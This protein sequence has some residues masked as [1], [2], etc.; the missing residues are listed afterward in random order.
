MN[1][2][3]PIDKTPGVRCPKIVLPRLAWAAMGLAFAC[4]F[5]PAAANAA[6]RKSLAAL[7][8][9]DTVCKVWIIFTDKNQPAG[10][11]SVTVRARVRRLR[12]GAG[13]RQFADDPVSPFYVKQVEALGCR[14]VNIFKWANAASFVI[15]SS[16]L[17]S[18]ARL[19]CVR[20]LLLVRQN[21]PPRRPAPGKALKKSAAQPPDSAYG[22]AYPELSMLAV[23]AAHRWLGSNRSLQ[24][25][26]GIVVAVFDAGFRLTHRCYSYLNQ[27]NLVLADSDFIDHDNTVNDPDSVVNDPTNPYWHNDEH[28]SMTLSLIAGYDP[29]NFLGVAWDAR[30]ILA[31]TEDSPV[32]KHYE[33][34]NWAAAMVWA[35]SLGVDIVSSS[36]GYNNG[37]TPPDTDYTFRDMDG[38]TTIIS[39]AASQA[40][41]LGVIIVNA[42]GNDG[43]DAGTISAPADTKD[44]V[45]VGAVDASEEIAWFS[46]RGPTA[47]GRIKP[48]CSALGVGA[49]I[50][51][52]YGASDNGQYTIDNGTSFSAPQV[53]G[54]AA[55]IL[56]AHPGDSASA[57]RNRLYSSCILAPG[58]VAPDNSFGRGIPNALVALAGSGFAL[59]VIVRD[60]T[61]SAAVVGTV[62]FKNPGDASFLSQRTDSS[63]TAIVTVSSPMPELY[64]VAPGYVAS[65]RISPILSQGTL[66][67]DTLFLRPRS[68]S[69]FVIYPNVLNFGARHQ[70][71]T[72]EFNA[73]PGA[74]GQTFSA[75]IRS[76][77]GAL[78]WHC[79]KQVGVSAAECRMVAPSK[80]CRLAVHPGAVSRRTCW[81][82]ASVTT[83]CS[84]WARLWARAE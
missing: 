51:Q 28:G 50:P 39:K 18:C 44:V 83:H 70:R 81:T 42:M 14:C 24:P 11:A 47:D 68:A 66:G 1:H 6:L 37:F 10:P 84:R 12:A 31:R 61:D 45:A 19:S 64:A 54:V 53:A 75:A 13:A 82:W 25:G 48:D 80:P 5:H 33:E 72:M 43:P 21:M 29:P 49:V 15:P 26:T 74:A 34:D 62:F 35:E 77:D 32:E 65:A 57:I 41:R 69:Q 52:I 27:H 60:S 9:R 7:A 79:E 36:L 17:D 78:V 2:S 8:A 73:E 3:A 55:L 4:G 20:D 30:F 16:K 46:S 40:A 63:G 56:Q 38:S 67:S 58:Q 23:P 71:L 22:L 76:V 59:R